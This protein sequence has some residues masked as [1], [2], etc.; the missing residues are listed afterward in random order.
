MYFIKPLSENIL[1][2]NKMTLVE[3][4]KYMDTIKYYNENATNYY[5]K[6]INIDMRPIYSE[7]LQYIKP[8]G[9]I[10]DAGCG[11]GRDSLYFLKNGYKVTAIDASEEMVKISSKLLNQKV[12]NMKFSE[13]NTINKFDGIWASASLLHI[14]KD[15]IKSVLEKF[16]KSLKVNGIVYM[17]FKYGDS[18]AIRDNRFYSDYNEDLIAKI[19]NQFKNIDTIKTWK[20][21]KKLSDRENETWLNIIFK[22]I[23]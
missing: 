20:T 4:S 13:I 21:Y 18:Q 19:L 9:H 8:H 15:K 11:S 3:E 16:L 14:S 10:L 17:S 2:V 7:F 22:K 5:K 12:L 6:T 23:N 1:T